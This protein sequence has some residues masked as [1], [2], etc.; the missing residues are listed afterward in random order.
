ML[1]DS[2]TGLPSDLEV[3]AAGIISGGQTSTS[4]DHHVL[5]D[6]LAP[7]TKWQAAELSQGREILSSRGMP[8]R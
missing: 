3:D 2:R 1:V 4:M 5:A 7:L 6:V 8:G